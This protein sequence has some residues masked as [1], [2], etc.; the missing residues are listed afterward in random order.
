MET[1]EKILMGIIT[2]I[3][4]FVFT[5]VSLAF[6]EGYLVAANACA[7]GSHSKGNYH[8][9]TNSNGVSHCTYGPKDAHGTISVP[10]EFYETLD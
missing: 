8:K 1:F 2:A 9:Y 6:Y 10:C 3:L 7:I 4:I 5:F